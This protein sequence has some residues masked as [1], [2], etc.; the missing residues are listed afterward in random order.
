MR[1]A[2]DRSPA[3]DDEDEA[4]YIPPIYVRA[5]ADYD[6][7]AAD[8]LSLRVGD[9]VRVWWV[10]GARDWWQGEVD[11]VDG[12]SKIGLFPSSFCVADDLR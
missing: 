10:A 11:E 9:R 7:T 4:Q 8:E 5:I 12:D 3:D 6:M 2:C 1:A